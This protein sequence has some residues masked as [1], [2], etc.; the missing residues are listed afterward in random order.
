[1]TELGF[2]GLGIMGKPMARNLLKA[3]YKLTVYDIRPEPMKELAA[4]GAETAS[5][6]RECVENA[7]KIITMLPDSADVEAAVLG[8]SGVVEGAKAGSTLI[9]MSSIAPL[10]AQKVSA[11]LAK[12]D[13]KMLDAPVSG[14]EKGAIEGTLA[15]MVGGPEA[16]FE[17]CVPIL[18]A[19]GKNVVRVGEIGAGS[20]TKLANQIVVAI[21]IE[22]VSEALILGTKAG[23]DPEKLYKAIR[24]GLAGSNVLDAKAPMIMDRNFAPGFKIRLHQKDLN[25]ALLTA[26]ELSV[27]LP[28]TGLVQQMLSS[29]I[30]GGQGDDDHGAICNVIEKLAGIEVKRTKTA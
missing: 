27:P 6:C 19:M 7:D 28:V 26:R 22:A 20:F 17:D 2:I 4:S 1:M 15:V 8:E 25:N 14:G 29:L 18:Q 9:D 5:S 21:N 24:G 13:I 30:A 23:V 11:E 10:V 3:G 12:R 16:V